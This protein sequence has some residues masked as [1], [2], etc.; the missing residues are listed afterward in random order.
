[1]LWQLL[2]FTMLPVAGLRRSFRCFRPH[3]RPVG[4]GGAVLV[5]LTAGEQVV[6]Q[7]ERGHGAD[8]A[9]VICVVYDGAAV[10]ARQHNEAQLTRRLLQTGDDLL[11]GQAADDADGGR[12][13]GRID[14]MC[15]QRGTCRCWLW[16]RPFSRRQ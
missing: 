15:T 3:L 11:P 10:D 6:Q 1:M 7:I 12:A 2:L 16:I 5:G 14:R 8:G 13:E 4:C 9:G